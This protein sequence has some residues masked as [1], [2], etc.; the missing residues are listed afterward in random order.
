MK[1]A[2]VWPW[3]SGDRVAPWTFNKEPRRK[4]VVHPRRSIRH[5]KSQNFGRV[6][7][8]AQLRDVF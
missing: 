4:Q 2:W 1:Q 6:D 8:A 5:W 7:E 3:G